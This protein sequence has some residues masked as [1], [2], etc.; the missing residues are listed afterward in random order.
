MESLDTRRNPAYSGAYGHKPTRDCVETPRD[1]P[2]VAGTQYRRECPPPSASI[3]CFTGTSAHNP[4]PTTWARTSMEESNI[5]QTPPHSLLF[6]FLKGVIINIQ[7]ILLSWNT[8]QVS[9]FIFLP[10]YPRKKDYKSFPVTFY[11]RGL[12]LSFWR[13]L[14]RKKLYH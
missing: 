7:N 8:S 4:P 10:Q 11:P 3:L 1:L 9:A 5:K 14:K 2:G 6:R 13:L 12:C